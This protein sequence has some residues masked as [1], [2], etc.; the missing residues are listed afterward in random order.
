MPTKG[1]FAS[2]RSLGSVPEM[3]FSAV[4][5]RFE[6]EESVAANIEEGEEVAGVF[7]TAVQKTLEFKSS[8]L[9]P[10]TRAA[11]AAFLRALMSEY[12]SQEGYTG[13]VIT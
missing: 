7:S 12:T 1:I 8:D 2:P 4:R 13:V 10:A 9:Q 11:L 5:I 3:R 6:D